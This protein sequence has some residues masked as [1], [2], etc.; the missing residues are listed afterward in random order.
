LTSATNSK[1]LTGLLASTAYQFQIQAVCSAGSSNYSSIAAFSTLSAGCSDP[2]EANNSR[3][4]ATLITANT[5]YNALVSPKNDNDYFKLTTVAGATNLRV[6]LDQLTLDYDLKLYNQAGTQLAVS[7]NAGTLAESI[8]RNTSTA[9]TYYIRVYGYSGANSATS[10]YRVIANT[11]GSAFRLTGTELQ[12]SAKIESAENI[13]ELNVYPNPASDQITVSFFNPFN[14]E[15]KITIIDMIGKSIYTNTINSE[16]GFN[17]TDINIAALT[18]GIYFI[19]VADS[20]S[21]TVKK[22]I[23][24]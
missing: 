22:F 24:K 8:T 12:N 6:D 14:S 11:S 13:D 7:Q 17:K 2:Y 19:K 20:S 3:T 10:C 5:Y 18:S 15:I 1:V 16:E 23:V 21:S 4:A 9:A